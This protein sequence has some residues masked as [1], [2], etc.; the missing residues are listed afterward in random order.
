M[1]MS[2][3]V[4]TWHVSAG[5]CAARGHRKFKVTR[6]P[7]HR[8]P[9]HTLTAMWCSRSRYRQALQWKCF[10]LL[11]TR[12]MRQEKRRRIQGKSI[13]TWRSSLL[14]M[15]VVEN[16][17]NVAIV[18]QKGATIHIWR[19][20][21]TWQW[22]YDLTHDLIG[23]YLASAR[24]AGPTRSCPRSGSRW[25]CWWSELLHCNIESWG[26]WLIR[27]LDSQMQNSCYW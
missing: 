25:R 16:V 5:S 1:P 7:R 14:I 4:V 26:R 15:C 3:L 12:K 17:G 6:P 21:H 13:S 9:R 2:L 18:Q 22:N 11:S 27:C 23:P 8:P 10:K 20:R 24:T 19:R